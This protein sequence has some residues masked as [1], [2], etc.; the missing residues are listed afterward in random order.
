MLEMTDSNEPISQVRRLCHQLCS[1]TC[2]QDKRQGRHEELLRLRPHWSVSRQEEQ[3]G[4]IDQGERVPFDLSLPL[5]ARD[6]REGSDAGVRL[7]WER[8][9]CQQ[10]G[11]AAIPRERACTWRKR[12]MK[13]SGG[14]WERRS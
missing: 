14:T 7:F 6:E 12:I 5:P 8:F 13:E 11:G 10:C 3:F 1:S 4:K 2:V 9:C